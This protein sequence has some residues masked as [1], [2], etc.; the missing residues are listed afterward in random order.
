MQETTSA[1]PT[2]YQKAPI[3]EAIVD[4]RVTP[5]EAMSV[6]DLRA[7]IRGFPSNIPPCEDFYRYSG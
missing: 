1:E 3:V 7:T 4:L 6:D 5:A 2:H